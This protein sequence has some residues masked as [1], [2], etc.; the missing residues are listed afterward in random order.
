MF[1]ATAQHLATQDIEAV[2]SSP[3]LWLAVQNPVAFAIKEFRKPGSDLHKRAS[4]S[5]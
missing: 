2:A 1:G 3:K 5:T 4:R